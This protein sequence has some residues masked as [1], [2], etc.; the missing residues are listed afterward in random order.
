MLEAEAT[1]LAAKMACLVRQAANQ[2]DLPAQTE[3]NSSDT[4]GFWHSMSDGTE[5]SNLTCADVGP[6]ESHIAYEPHVEPAPTPTPAPVAVPAPVVAAPVSECGDH[7]MERYSLF[8]D[9]GLLIQEAQALGLP[10]RNLALTRGA[11]AAAKARDRSRALGLFHSTEGHNRRLGSSGTV[12]ARPDEALLDASGDP[13]GVCGD[14]FAA[15]SGNA[16]AAAGASCAAAVARACPSRS[17]GA[18]A[19]LPTLHEYDFCPLVDTSVNK[20]NTLSLEQGSA[21]DAWRAGH[22]TRDRWVSQWTTATDTFGCVQCAAPWWLVNSSWSAAACM[23]FCQGGEVVSMLQAAVDSS[24]SREM[25]PFGVV[26]DGVSSAHTEMQQT[27]M[28]QSVHAMALASNDVLA[29]LHLHICSPPTLAANFSLA[30]TSPL[31]RLNIVPGYNLSGYMHNATNET[32]TPPPVDKAE[33]TDWATQFACSLP[34][35]KEKGDVLDDII[36]PELG[37]LTWGMTEEILCPDDAMPAEPPTSPPP[38]TPPHPPPT[39]PPPPLPAPSPAPVVEANVRT[40][41]FGGADFTEAEEDENRY[42]FF[43]ATPFRKNAT[44]GGLLRDAEPQEPFTNVYSPAEANGTHSD[45]TD[46]AMDIQ[47][48]LIPVAPLQPNERLA[49]GLAVAVVVL[50]TLLAVWQVARYWRAHRVVGA[51][52]VGDYIPYTPEERGGSSRKEEEPAE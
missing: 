49:L 24:D 14:C 42:P 29:V 10:N 38:E 23:H 35:M 2:S 52:A 32:V 41:P 31:G 9:L 12:A 28:Q 22:C 30:S 37:V 34:R 48:N 39:P 45:G 3:V 4:G 50:A 11:K 44:R 27:Q 25:L 7:D 5:P 20:I 51:A 33:A 40:H 1:Y 13:A 17:P 21:V 6:V 19:A 16:T 26:V 47:H 43:K 36:I 8:V 15:G 18:A 46:Y